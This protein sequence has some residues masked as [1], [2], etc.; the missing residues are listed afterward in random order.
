[1]ASQQL[2]IP[3]HLK[4]VATLPREMFFQKS[5]WPRSE[6]SELPRTSQPF[7][8][9]AQ[10]YSSGDVSV[11]LF[12]DENNIYSDHTE[13]PAEWPTARTS[14]NQ[15]ERRRDKTPA[16]VIINV[17]SQM[18]SVGEQKVVDITPVWHLPITE[19]V[20]VTEEY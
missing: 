8:T 20:L 17:Q 9:V 2:N 3:P 7:K 11:V 6:W 15:E 18:A 13:N 10:K 1:M 19:S 12:T 16:H 5:Q 14:V 4:C